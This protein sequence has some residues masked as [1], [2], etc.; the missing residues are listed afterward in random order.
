M[1]ITCAVALRFLPAGLA[2][3]LLVA[4]AAAEKLADAQLQSFISGKRVYLAVPLG[5]EI[6]LTYRAGGV[7]DGSGEAV[8]LG[9]YMTPKD[10][11]RWWVAGE[12]L[13]QKWQQWYGGKTFCFTVTKLTGNKI[14]WVRDDGKSGVARLRQTSPNAP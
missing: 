5:G 10:R 13:C 7:V 14:K 9:K 6:P 1:I 2:L 12:R 8:G 11:G 3:A 4:P